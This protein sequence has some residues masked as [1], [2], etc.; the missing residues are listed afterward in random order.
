MQLLFDR[1]DEAEGEG[2]GIVPGHV[3]RIVAP[4]VPHM[5]WNEVRPTADPL[6]EGVG[7]APMYFAN[8]YH[9]VPQATDASIAVTEYAGRDLVSAVRTLNCWGVQYHPE[10]SS[11][12]GRRLLKNFVRF[13]VAI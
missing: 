10:K 13:A 11:T 5:G 3:E 12:P 6:F 8:S 4:I 2:L 9:C 7:N 1:S